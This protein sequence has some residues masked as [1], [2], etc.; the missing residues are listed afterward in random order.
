MRNQIRFAWLFT[1]LLCPFQF[2]F[3]VWKDRGLIDLFQWITGSYLDFHSD[4]LELWF[5]IPILFLLGWTLAYNIGDRINKWKL[6]EWTAWSIAIVLISYGADKIKMEQFPSP[7]VNLLYKPLHEFDKDLLFWT[8]MGTS[9]LYNLISGCIEIALAIL[10]IFPASRKIGWMSTTVS[11][12]YILL[13]NLSFNISVKAFVSF[14][15]VLSLFEA[16]PSF[17]RMVIY[18]WDRQEKRH[19]TIFFRIVAFNILAVIALYDFQDKPQI[20]EHCYRSNTGNLFITK[21][22]YWIE[23]Q[24]NGKVDQARIISQLNNE[25]W[26]Q[27]PNGEQTYRQIK[28]EKDEVYSTS[29]LFKYKLILKAENL[30]Q[31]EDPLSFISR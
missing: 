11:L 3:F 9:S 12:C 24:T 16:F 25:Y 6:E 17:Q 7:E 22:G 31:I 4:S 21:Q 10:L 14:L 18:L 19:K 20:D 8:S 2:S 29:S 26:L 15:L 28:K 5:S 27:L 23:K 1:A 30:P 13:L